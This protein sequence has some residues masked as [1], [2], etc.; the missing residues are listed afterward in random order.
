MTVWSYISTI[1][2]WQ[3][4]VR[5]ICLALICVVLI[6]TLF[7]ANFAAAAPST[8][9]V[10]N[11]QG[12]LQTASGAVVPDGYYNIQFKIYQGGS[13]SAAG[14][15]GGS[16]NWTESYVNNSTNAG[17]QV[18]NGLFSVSLGSKTSFGSSVDWENANLWLSMNVAGRD[19]A[20]SSFGSAPCVA[21]GEM[22]PMKRITAVPY[23]ISAGAVGGKTADDLVQLGQG[24]QTDASNGTSISINKT[25]TGDLVQLQNAATDVL[26]IAGNG[27]ITMGSGSAQSISVADSPTGDGQSLS[28]TAGSATTGDSNGGDLVLAAGSGSGSGAE[29]NIIMN[30]DVTIGAGHTISMVGGNTALRPANPTKGMVYFDSETNQLLVYNGTK[31]AGDSKASTAVVAASDSRQSIK[32]GAGYVADNE[33]VIGT[34]TIDGDQ[35]EI[36]AAIN[37]LPSSGGVV[38]LAA[39]SYY[40]DG[41]IVLPSN[42]TLLGS[43]DST[44]LTI[45]NQLGPGVTLITNSD[46]T[47]GNTG[48]KIRD[49]KLDGNYSNNGSASTGYGIEMV[50]VGTSSAPGLSVSNSTF[51]DFRSSNIYLSDS[52]NSSINNSSFSN[53]SGRAIDIA[54]SQNIQI[55]SN[56]FENVLVSTYLSV[57]SKSTFTNNQVAASSLQSLN[58]GVMHITDYST[59]NKITNNSFIDN[60]GTAVF[61]SDSHHNLIADNSFVDNGGNSTLAALRVNNQAAGNTL[62]DNLFRD[63]GG[64]SPAIEVGSNAV[65][66]RLSNNSL[67]K[68]SANSISDSSPTSTYSNQL[69]SSGR[70]IN[71]S[72]GGFNVQTSAGSDAMT[73]DADSGTIAVAGTLEAGSLQAASLD[74]AAASPLSI[75]ATNATSVTIGTSDT[76][77]TTLV[78]DTK[79]DAG[80]PTGVNGAMYYSA[81]AGA[82]RCYQAG[83]WQDCITPL[84]VYK[85]TTSSYAIGSSATDIPDMSFPLAA[86]TKYH[87]KFVIKH[88]AADG[89]GF[90][91]TT[92]TSSTGT[93]WCTSVTLESAS[94]T[95]GP[96]SSAYCGTGDAS[97]IISDT[98]M[99][100]LGFVSIMEGYVQTASSVGNLKLRGISGSTNGSTVNSQSFGI[101]QIVQ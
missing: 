41:N 83:S 35:I 25:G 7:L 62:S 44:I 36:N 6:A 14:N 40:L 8:D 52:E 87:Y 26:T 13:G 95:P 12:R 42:V 3:H 46:H 22:L 5:K 4:I 39:G 55:A 1:F 32:D 20:C 53:G 70:L 43:G 78:L 58:I 9:R 92:P 74:T 63:S 38:Y 94:D 48:I 84:P 86:N 79:T 10:I 34:G 56:N 50:K 51:D 45:N 27:N 76:T 73:I 24:L 99:P 37:S 31:W 67:D 75:A 65:N 61:V 59:Y 33:A 49:L 64:T 101:V 17:V 72:E 21:D 68:W 16:L 28:L 80:D 30:S 71:R 91:V 77:G 98:Y 11:F 47:N 15:P 23:A 96:S 2:T 85:T 100:G 88:S 57:T 18:K 60:S 82:F 93:N 29:G 66:T 54:N 89:A 90:G 81:D 19:S 97:T 69:D